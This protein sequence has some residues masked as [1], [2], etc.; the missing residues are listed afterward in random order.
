MVCLMLRGSHLL[1]MKRKY[2]DILICA[3]SLIYRFKS[4]QLILECFSA[5]GLRY[6]NYLGLVFIDLLRWFQFFGT[7]SSPTKKSQSTTCRLILPFPIHL[8]PLR[9]PTQLFL[10][11]HHGHGREYSFFW[12]F[13]IPANLGQCISR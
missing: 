11:S 5:N 7:L 9:P 1:I 12:H 10:F 2:T 8:L 4:K 13:L 3:L 6:P